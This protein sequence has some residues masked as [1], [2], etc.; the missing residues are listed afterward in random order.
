M[1][2]LFCFY[3]CY[4]VE[5]YKTEKG[6]F[7]VRFLFSKAQRSLCKLRLKFVQTT[8]EVSRNDMPPKS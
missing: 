6:K 5:I 8:A 7:R 2:Y 4:V 1:V 3:V